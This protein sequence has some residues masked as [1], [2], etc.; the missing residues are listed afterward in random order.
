ME[1]S[2]TISDYSN[3]RRYLSTLEME[4]GMYRF[5]TRYLSD[6]FSDVEQQQRKAEQNVYMGQNLVA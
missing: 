1:I 4:L 3:S 5:L 2:V 6:L